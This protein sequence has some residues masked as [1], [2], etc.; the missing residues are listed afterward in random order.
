M[1]EPFLG[2]FRD[3]A[4]RQ[5][6]PSYFLVLLVD[7]VPALLLMLYSIWPQVLMKVAEAPWSVAEWAVALGFDYPRATVPVLVLG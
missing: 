1:A 4:E 7:M 3:R 5:S 6:V 2:L